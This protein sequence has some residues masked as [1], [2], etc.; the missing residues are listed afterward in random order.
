MSAIP[1][2]NFP[3]FRL[4]TERHSN[5]YNLNVAVEEAH[6]NCLKEIQIT[7][8]ITIVL[9]TGYWFFNLIMCHYLLAAWTD[10]G[11]CWKLFLFL[12]FV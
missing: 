2:H 9:V 11:K 8:D 1:K 4:N 3:A 6:L 5:V 12:H 10:S 7:E